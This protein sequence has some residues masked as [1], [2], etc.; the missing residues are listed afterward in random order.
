VAPGPAPGAPAVFGA[1]GDGARGDG[2]RGDAAGKPRIGLTSEGRWL[3][4]TGVVFML[5][6]AVA[7]TPGVAAFGAFALTLLAVA[8]LA[9]VLARHRIARLAVKL[10]AA[11]PAMKLWEGRTSD[12][13]FSLELPAGT[14]V[15]ALDLAPL[16]SETL[17]GRLHAAP[18]EA[19][20]ASR[21]QRFRLELRGLRLGDS[22]LQGFHLTATVALGLY[23][24]RA[25]APCLLRTTVLPRHMAS[26]RPPLR[27]TRA[28]ADEQ[29]DLVHR[30]KRGFGME[31]RELRDFQAGDPFKHIAW[32]AS[33]R[34][35]KLIAREFESDLQLSIWLLVDCSPSMFWG[36]A[37]H[38]KIDHALEIAADLARSLASGRDRVGLVLHDHESRLFIEA[39]HGSAHLT[40]LTQALLEA[41]HLVH[42]D[43]TELTDIELTLRVAR[44]FEV[45]EGRTFYL[46]TPLP[47]EPTLPSAPTLAAQRSP[48]PIAPA[49]SERRPLPPREPHPRALRVDEP[50]LARACRQLLERRFTKQ[51]PIVPLGA[52]ALEANRST[53]RAF[54]RHAGIALPRDPTPRPGGQAHGLEAA[55]QAVLTAHGHAGA[56]TL[57]SISDFH[58]AD[59]LDALRRVALTARRHRHSLVF[60]MP[61]GDRGVLPAGSF[62]RRS[63]DARLMTALVEVAALQA[64]ENLRRAQAILRPAGA[65]F[66]HASPGDS[67][68]RVLT[69]LRAVA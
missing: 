55:L 7:S 66:V 35:G 59:D 24:V 33:A 69:K 62:V 3:G 11:A 40:R 61:T 47:P 50:A 36:P 4:L 30:E 10:D 17:D 43:R 26:G 34:R 8:H 65:T 25:F 37:G 38:A 63:Q 49:L 53:L 56:H 52:Y 14:A 41:P 6:G 19:D 18:S 39:G 16:L 29:A 44:W 27:A 60:V 2:A 58:T 5:A 32:S 1:R 12:V 57:L 67:L 9:A 21:T 48:S 51:R 28:A 31:I 64:D 20:G 42:E 45:H 54:A 15:Y 22:W 23:A 46:A 13:T 68:G